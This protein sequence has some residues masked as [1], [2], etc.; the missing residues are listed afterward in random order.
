MID[1]IQ[2]KLELN[3]V[4]TQDEETH[5]NSIKQARRLELLK[6]LSAQ[7]SKMLRIADV[8]MADAE[9]RYKLSTEELFEAAEHPLFQAPEEVAV[10]PDVEY[11]DEDG[12]EEDED[13]AEYFKPGD[14]RR[15]V[16]PRKPLGEEHNRFSNSSKRA[17]FNLT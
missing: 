17:R 10:V 14:K 16:R 3:A 8:E 11:G 13:D 15:R 12:D 1:S 6:E 7:G 9:S 4:R 2:S 5:R